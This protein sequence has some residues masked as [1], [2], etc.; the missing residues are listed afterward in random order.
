[1]PKKHYTLEGMGSQL[2]PEFNLVEMA[3]PYLLSDLFRWFDGINLPRLRRIFV[4]DR[5]ISRGA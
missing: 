3:T 4:S 5:T 1:L 2:D